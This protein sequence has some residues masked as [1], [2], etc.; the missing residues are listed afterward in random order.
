MVNVVRVQI[1]RV[2]NLHTG[3]TS[4]IQLFHHIIV[5]PTC[6]MI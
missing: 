4:G 6:S 5:M 1:G 2:E 3:Q